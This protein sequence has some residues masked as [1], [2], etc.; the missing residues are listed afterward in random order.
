MIQAGKTPLQLA[1]EKKYSE[2]A[3]LLKAGV[4]APGEGGRR[5]LHEN[6]CNSSPFC[7]AFRLPCLYSAKYQSNKKHSPRSCCVCHCYHGGRGK[8]KVGGGGGN[9]IITCTTR[10]KINKQTFVTPPTFH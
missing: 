5:G 10:K 9:R 6:G 7:C 3:A 2:I 4:L 1:E 8:L